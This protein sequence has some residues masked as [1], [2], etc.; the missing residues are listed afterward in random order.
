MPTP[1]AGN[2]RSAEEPNPN[3]TPAQSGWG[4]R[5]LLGSV[6]RFIPG[7][8]A[9]LQVRN[10]NPVTPPRPRARGLSQSVHSDPGERHKRKRASPEQVQI[11]HDERSEEEKFLA[12][13]KAEQ[14]ERAKRTKEIYTRKKIAPEQSRA[15]QQAAARLMAAQKPDRE[16]KRVRVAIDSLPVIPSRRKD[17]CSGTYRMCEEFFV[18]SDD[19]D[20]FAEIS[21]WDDEVP[22]DDLLPLPIAKKARTSIDKTAE[23][24][25]TPQFAPMPRHISAGAASA[26]A[27]ARSHRSGD[28]SHVAPYTGRLFTVPTDSTEYSGGNVF[29][30]SDRSGQPDPKIAEYV[31]RHGHSDHDDPNFDRE[32]HFIVP[33][34]SSSEDESDTAATS[35]GKGK[36]PMRNDQASTGA[37]SSLSDANKTQPETGSSGSEQQSWTQPP[38]PRPTP[39]HASLPGAAGAAGAPLGVDALARARSQ[40][41]KY[42]PKQPSGLRASSRLSTSSIG[43]DATQEAAQRKFASSGSGLAQELSSGDDAEMSETTPEGGDTL[44]AETGVD[45]VSDDEQFTRAPIAWPAVRYIE[46]D[47]VVAAAVRRAD[48][49]HNALEDFT[50]A[51][52]EYLERKRQAAGVGAL[53]LQ[54]N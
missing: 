19:E 13:A 2:V 28:P 27:S 46:C 49:S 40:A 33:E 44:D 3:P 37:K 11:I 17:D 18:Q 29:G 26:S 22:W 51:F 30:Q 14:E 21:L 4:L 35:S 45:V 8:R 12:N 48:A 47:P 42:K 10:G 24:E 16:R 39:A 53:P 6:T 54:A 9:P 50:K 41:E 20:H 23:G 1:R 52:E 43:S 34:G 7:A 36:A 32:G 31:G 25:K 15:A 5:S 38:P